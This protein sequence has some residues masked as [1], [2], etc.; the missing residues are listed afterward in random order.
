MMEAT[1]PPNPLSRRER[2][3]QTKAIPYL[4]PLR[5]SSPLSLRERG[6]GGVR[7]RVTQEAH[8]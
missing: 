1:S 3:N 2:G 5:S 8:P 7:F 6:A 4:L